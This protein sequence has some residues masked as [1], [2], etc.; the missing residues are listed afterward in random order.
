MGMLNF[1]KQGI[2]SAR[3]DRPVHPLVRAIRD[4]RTNLM[5]GT[6][7]RGGGRISAA[8]ILKTRGSK[9]EFSRASIP[10]YAAHVGNA[11]RDSSIPQT[12]R[13]VWLLAWV[14]TLAFFFAN[15][16]VQIEGGGGWA[17]NLPTWRVENHRLIDIFWSGRPFTG[18]HAW[19]F[20]FMALVFHLPLF[21]IGRWNSRLEA[22]VLGG[23]AIF[24]I[25]EDFLWFAINPAFGLDK[26]NP[27]NAWWHIHWLLGVPVDY[28][29]FGLAGLALFRYSFSQASDARKDRR[30]R[31]NGPGGDA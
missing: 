2:D 21:V 12:L 7:H 19:V 27:E 8:V 9:A 26:F 5:S 23:V 16:E 10:E 6:R 17:T 22:R 31:G 29:T 13:P 4:N 1:G 20:A 3:A 24:W 25:V 30:N 11:N 28:L 14:V 15:V 18:Y